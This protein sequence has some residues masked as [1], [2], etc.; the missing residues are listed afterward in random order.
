MS[1]PLV[2]LKAQY[3]TIKP[4]IDAAVARIFA[5]TSFIGGAEVTG[6]EERMADYC[7]TRY[8][9]GLSSGT[10]ALRLA[11]QALGI[12][13]GD[14]VIT[15]AFTFI[16]TAAAI[17][18]VGATPLLV[19]IDERTY[20]INPA[21]VEAAITPRTKAIIPVDLYGQPADMD[22]IMAI[23]REH[24][25]RVI[26][27]ACQAIGATYKGRK[28]GGLGDVGCFSFY[29]SKNLGGAGDGGMVVTSDEALTDKIRM[30]RDHGR[31]T[32]YGHALVGYTNR[33]DALQAAVLNVKLEHLD[34]WN[35]ARRQHA[36]TFSAALAGTGCVTPYEAEGC[37]S[38]YHVYAVRVPGDRDTIVADLRERG[39]GA[40]V[41]YPMPVY[42]QPAY[43]D[44]GQP[45]GSCPVTEAC[46]ASIMS[47]PMYPELTE[48]Q[49]DTV[50]NALR[51][52]LA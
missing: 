51:D 31:T 3:R 9:I 13:P 5:N 14:E 10:A 8:A 16:A 50:V 12:G 25:L 26:E 32:H 11:L 18:H 40:G 45:A 21:S 24:K 43:A 2:D 41:H 38:V 20:N 39:I 34:R 47:L 27:D 35:E 19:D 49:I 15:T 30:L 23:A 33:L 7:Q 6:F 52:N 4:E 48:E 22:A 46:S 36:A 37:R 28:A 17:S 42:L 44:L 29:P 1:V